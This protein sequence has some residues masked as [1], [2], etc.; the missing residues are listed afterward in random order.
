MGRDISPICNH[1]LNISNVETLAIDLYD[2]LEVN[3]LFGGNLVYYIDDQS[4]K[5]EGVGLGEESRY[6]WE[7]LENFI[8]ETTGDLLLDIPQY[9]L[10]NKYKLDCLKKGKEPLAFIDDFR[11][12][13]EQKIS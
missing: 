8:K 13:K 7:E 4:D 2:R 3:I 5:L 12:L 11:D 1:N 6:S 10:N 9:F